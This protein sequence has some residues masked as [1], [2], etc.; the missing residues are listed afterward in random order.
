[1]SVCVVVR[2]TQLGT[3]HCEQ[4]TQITL[5]RRSQIKLAKLGF[6]SR[7]PPRLR[8]G[9]P[10]KGTV[11]W[12]PKLAPWPRQPL[13]G[14][15]GRETSVG[16]PEEK[17]DNNPAPPLGTL[18]GTRI[19]RGSTWWPTLELYEGSRRWHTNTYKQTFLKLCHRCES[20]AQM[21]TSTWR[22]CPRPPGP[23]SS[24]WSRRSPSARTAA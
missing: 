4:S 6:G 10:D 5:W 13:A 18:S 19:R 15:R 8:W 1:M 24:C 2:V 9:E 21:A 20:G 12:T 11:L 22:A 16:Q 3:Q 14:S 23:T 7:H 17:P